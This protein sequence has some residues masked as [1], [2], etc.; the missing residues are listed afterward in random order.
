MEDLVSNIIIVNILDR[1]RLVVLRNELPSVMNV[2]RLGRSINNN[3]NNRNILDRVRLVVEENAL[4]Y[5]V[6]VVN[7]GRSICIIPIFTMYFP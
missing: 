1:V 4:M 3:N 6:N 7:L 5:V 2:V